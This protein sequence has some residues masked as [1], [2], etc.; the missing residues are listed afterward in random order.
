MTRENGKTKAKTQ[1]EGK[2]GKGKSQRDNVSILGGIREKNEATGRLV[3][4]Q[5][6][7]FKI[8]PTNQLFLLSRLP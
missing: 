4:D 6:F 3:I 8:F 7:K 5:Q 1:E 2:G